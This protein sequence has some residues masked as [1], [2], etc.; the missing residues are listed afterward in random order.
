[1]ITICRKAFFYGRLRRTE[2]AFFE[3]PIRIELHSVFP[4]FLVYLYLYSLFVV[5]DDFKLVR[6][7][8]S[9]SDAWF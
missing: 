7:R 4:R 6:A 9:V 2:T 8:D 1:M 5:L 3:V